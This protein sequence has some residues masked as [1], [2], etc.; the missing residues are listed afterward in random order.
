MSDNA[1]TKTLADAEFETDNR[2]NSLFELPFQARYPIEGLVFYDT[3]RTGRPMYAGLGAG[4]LVEGDL[5]LQR[6]ERAIQE[7]YDTIDTMR[8]A[9]PAAPDKPLHYRIRREC[10]FALEVIPAEGA[11]FEERLA[12]ASAL[13]TPYASKLETYADA[14]VR[15][16]VYDLGTA[17]SGEHAWIVAFSANHLAIDDQAIYL[18]INQFMANYRGEGKMVVHESNLLDYLNFMNDNPDIVDARA[19]R[20][21]W[22]TERA[23]Y[24]SPTLGEAEPD[25]TVPVDPSDLVFYLD[26]QQVK[27]L[28]LACQTT[29]PSL[30]MAALHVGTAAGFGQL[31][32][33]ICMMTE[34]RPHF[35]FW[36]TVVHGL[37]AMNNRMRLDPNEPFSEFARRTLLKMSENLQNLVSE[38]Y[39]GGAAH[40]QYTY[41]SPVRK[42]N[43]GEGLTC[44]SW[45][46][47]LI[48]DAGY[49][50]SDVV[51]VVEG[52]DTMQVMQVFNPE[53]CFLTPNEVRAF[54]CGLKCCLEMAIDNPHVRIGE[55]MSAAQERL[56]EQAR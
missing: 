10:P 47:N 40:V 3:G 15:A 51:A 18:V 39:V 21:Y 2:G 26:T 12:S 50:P 33:A 52:S 43:L 44:Q 22:Q 30:F 34:S 29:L 45:M 11:T 56:R 17:P 41:V 20:A 55:I 16:V 31:D 42:P 38:E 6:T 24:E 35:S 37:M 54:G 4:L 48:G 1:L 9:Y 14:S 46:P 23:G 13:E 53:Q 19:N 25:R 27:S 7:L 32:S 28:A 36:N 8:V 5:D 49:L